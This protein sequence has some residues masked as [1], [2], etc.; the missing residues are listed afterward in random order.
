MR[1]SNDKI[2]S[3]LEVQNSVSLPPAEG[4]AIFKTLQAVPDD[5]LKEYVVAIQNNVEDQLLIKNCA[6]AKDCP[7]LYKHLTANL[8]LHQL[9][10]L[11]YIVQHLATKNPLEKIRELSRLTFDNEPPTDESVAKAFA[12]ISLI[13]SSKADHKQK[14]EELSKLSAQIQLIADIFLVLGL[15]EK[16]GHL[17]MVKLSEGFQDDLDSLIKLTTRNFMDKIV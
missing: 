11:N 13:Q 10:K 3:I 17:I 5:I 12:L 8:T 4:D 6:L 7:L 1:H 16:Y 2:T 15:D 14:A 9:D